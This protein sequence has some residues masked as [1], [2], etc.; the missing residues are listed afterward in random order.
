MHL[1]LLRDNLLGIHL[2]VGLLGRLVSFVLFLQL[3]CQL[4]IHSVIFLSYSGQPIFKDISFNAMGHLLNH[5]SFSIQAIYQ[6]AS[7]S[8]S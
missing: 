5:F 1:A 6:S 8:A 3:G 4:I 2:L 7:S